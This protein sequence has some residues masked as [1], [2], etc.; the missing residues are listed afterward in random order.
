M[1]LASN[2]LFYFGKTKQNKTKMFEILKIG[3]INIRHNH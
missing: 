3:N 1:K 2:F